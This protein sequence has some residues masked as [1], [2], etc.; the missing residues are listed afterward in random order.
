MTEMP[1]GSTHKDVG[2]FAGQSARRVGTIK[3]EIDKIGKV[4]DLVQLYEIA[5]DCSWSP[6]ARLYSAAR[7]I[8]GLQRAAEH[9]QLRPDI[10]VEDIEARTA[11]LNSL[12]WADPD[13]HCCLLDLRRER[14][15]V[16]EQ[17]LLDE[18]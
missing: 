8:G 16:R 6:E 4:S 1:I 5:G 10:S 15:A 18:E 9:R 2:I 13:F 3:K 17:P 12:T 14:A 11:G 7:C